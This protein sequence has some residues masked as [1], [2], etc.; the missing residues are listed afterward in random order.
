MVVIEE[1]EGLSVGPATMDGYIRVSRKMGREGPGYIS[2]KIQREA[3]ERWA[4][5]R[6]VKIVRWHVD[7]DE[8]GGTQN[9]PGMLEAMRRVEARETGGIACWRLNRFARNVSEAL[10]DVSR[11]HAAGG[12]LAFIEEDIDPTGPFGEFILIILLA[13]AALEL[14]NIKAGW[15]GAKA[16][17]MKRGAVM[18]P[19]PYGFRRIQGGDHE[20]ELELDEVTAAIMR[21]AFTIA[22]THGLRAT[23]AYLVEHGEGRVWTMSTVR[24][25]LKRTC[26]LGE[27]HYNGKGKDERL[28]YSSAELAIVDKAT[29]LAAQ[30]PEPERRQRSANFPLTGLAI[31]E[32]CG[33][34]MVGGRGGRDRKT[35]EGLRQYRC[36]ASL[37]MWKGERCPAPA[38]MVASRLEDYVRDQAA[39]AAAAVPSSVQ[40]AGELEDELAL[41][42]RRVD[43]AEHELDVAMRDLTLRRT[44]GDARYHDAIALRVDAVDEC[45]AHY[46]VLAARRVASRKLVN[47]EQL[48]REAEPEQ[49]GELLRGMLSSVEVTRGRGPVEDRVRLVVA[50]DDEPA[51]RIALVHDA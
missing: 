25:T 48:L 49:L 36:A 8:S 41:A 27:F 37:T 29:W 44:L 43:E 13:V 47:L 32:T 30:P 16:T 34:H 42:G 9:R 26:Y 4:A 24:R 51:A 38:T 21:R 1:A 40:D 20:G 17:A 12:V 18:G 22:A 5:Y 23:L 31:C 28:K 33:T 11:V 50:D 6:G 3:I 2:P 19:T 35:G 7:E 15:R 14:N 46:K 39:A 10:Q 45:Q